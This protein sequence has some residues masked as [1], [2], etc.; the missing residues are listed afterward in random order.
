MLKFMKRSTSLKECSM[1]GINFNPTKVYHHR[2]WDCQTITNPPWYLD[3]D[4]DDLEQFIDYE[5]FPTI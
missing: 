3:L 5:G 2:C 1:C 4:P